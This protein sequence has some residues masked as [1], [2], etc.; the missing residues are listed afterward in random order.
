MPYPIKAEYVTFRKLIDAYSL[1]RLLNDKN[2]KKL[3]ETYEVT[4]VAKNNYILTLVRND[5]R[6]TF[7]DCRGDKISGFGDADA[8]EL[9]KYYFPEDVEVDEYPIKAR[10]LTFG[11]M[12]QSKV[13]EIM[14][15]FRNNK[16]AEIKSEYRVGKKSK[17]DYVVILAKPNPNNKQEFNGAHVSGFVDVFATALVGLYFPQDV[18]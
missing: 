17:N 5:P 12:D 10:Y 3:K 9:I 1:V 16:Q 2:N 6:N 13:T 7:A 11:G 14:N 15:K 4:R 18:K 8:T